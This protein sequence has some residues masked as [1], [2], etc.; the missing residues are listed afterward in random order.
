MPRSARDLQAP[1]PGPRLTHH[2]VK[3]RAQFDPAQCGRRLEY[4]RAVDPFL[5]DLQ[6]VLIAQSLSISK[7]TGIQRGEVDL[8][9]IRSALQ[10]AELLSQGYREFAARHLVSGV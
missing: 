7:R 2:E 9:N 5:S 8:K 10:Q 1:L 6:Q 4:M 3:L